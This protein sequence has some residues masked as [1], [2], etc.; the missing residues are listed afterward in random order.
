MPEEQQLKSISPLLGLATATGSLSSLLQIVT[1]FILT[2][3]TSDFIPTVG[4]L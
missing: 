3:Q 1:K 2:P 4:I